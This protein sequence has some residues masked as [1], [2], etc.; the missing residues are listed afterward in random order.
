MRETFSFSFYFSLL[1]KCTKQTKNTRVEALKQLRWVESFFR[2]EREASERE[3]EW[4]KHS[5]TSFF[6]RG[7]TFLFFLLFSPS[8]SSFFAFLREKEEKEAAMSW[9]QWMLDWLRR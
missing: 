8:L 2:V 3:R 9:Y 6:A 4:K 1:C 7:K 5:L